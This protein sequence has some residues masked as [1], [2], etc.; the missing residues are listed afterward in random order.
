MERALR[1][2]R[3]K[4][5]R[6]ERLDGPTQPGVPDVERNHLASQSV[7]RLRFEHDAVHDTER[8]ERHLRCG[9][10]R[11]VANRFGRDASLDSSQSPKSLV[12]GTRARDDEGALSLATTRCTEDGVVDGAE[13]ER[14]S[15]S[16]GGNR[17]RDPLAV[18]RADVR[19][20]PDPLSALFKL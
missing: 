4:R 5:Q 1:A 8:A 9:E 3:V 16:A 12:S 2:V 17:A 18:G 20:R 11:V 13:V 19:A 6:I 10:D 14:R 15:V 7:E